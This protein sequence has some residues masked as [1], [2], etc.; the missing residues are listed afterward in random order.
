MATEAQPRSNRE[1]YQLRQ[2][3][4]TRRRAP[5]SRARPLEFDENGFPV[6]QALPGFMQRVARLINGT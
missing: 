3:E 4:T 5:D 6:P 1:R 2:R